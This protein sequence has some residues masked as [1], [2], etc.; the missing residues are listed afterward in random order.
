MFVEERTNDAV[1]NGIVSRKFTPRNCLKRIN[2]KTHSKPFCMLFYW[3]DIYKFYV[4][5]SVHLGKIY[6]Q[7]KEQLV[8]LCTYSLLFFILSSTCFGCYLHP[9]S[10]AQLQ[11]TAIGVY[12]YGSRGYNS[13][14]RCGVLF[15]A[16]TTNHT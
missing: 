9:S 3:K 12:I 16:R 14:N 13:I 10:G 11:R 5:G 1:Q 6:V 4:H 7:L 8:V 2:T 15:F